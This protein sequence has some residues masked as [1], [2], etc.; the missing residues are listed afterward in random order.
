[1]FDYKSVKFLKCSKCGE[2]IQF[3]SEFII[4]ERDENE[5]I[6]S[7][8]A[9]KRKYDCN[10]CTYENHPAICLKCYSNRIW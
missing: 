10:K 1:M 7:I 6:C 3:E 2:L 4:P 8:C 9:D 5:F